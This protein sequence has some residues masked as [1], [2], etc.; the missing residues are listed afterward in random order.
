MTFGVIAEMLPHQIRREAIETRGHGGMRGEEIPSP[1]HLE[2]HL[3]RLPRRFH[4]IQ[5]AFQCGEGGVAFIQMANF[6][7]QSQRSQEPP[8]ADAQHDLLGDAHLHPAT[9]EFVGDAAHK[10]RVFRV[11]KIQQI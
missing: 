6:G 5:G 1:G 4:E 2:R 10:G 8:A 7:I 11:V 9:I 3:K